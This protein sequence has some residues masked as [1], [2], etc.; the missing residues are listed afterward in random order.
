MAGYVRQDVANEIEDGNTILAA[1]IDAEYDALASSFSASSGHK[2]D[3]TVGEGAPITVVG[4]SQNLIVSANS[5]T[6]KTDD[7]IDLGSP[8]LEFKD[9]YIDGVANVDSLVADAATVGGVAVTTATNTQTLTG[10]TINLTDNTLVATSAQ[11]ATAVTDET[12]TGNLVFSDSPALTGVPTAPTAAPGTDTTQIATTAYV[13][14]E[15]DVVAVLT[16]KTI[17]LSDNTLVATSAEL[18]AA[19]SDETGSGSLVF[20]NSPSLTGTPTAPTATTGNNTTQ[21][22]TTAFVKTAIDGLSTL[23]DATFNNPTINGGTITGGSISSLDTDLP[24]ADGGTGASSAPAARTALGLAIG[25]DVQAY[26]AGLQSISGLTTVA[27]RMLYTTGSDT[28]AVT[29]ITSLGRAVVGASTAADARTNLGLGTIA[30]QAASAVTITGGSITGIT[31]LPVADGG[32]GASTSANARTNLGLAIG[33]DVQ[34]YDAGLQSISGLT[35]SA[36]KMIYT[37]ASDTYSAATLTSFARTLLDDANAAAMQ[38]TLGLGALA[39][40]NKVAVPSDINATGTPSGNTVLYG[41]GNWGPSPVAIANADPGVARIVDA[42]L[43]TT[44][45][46]AGQD[47]VAARMIARGHGGI[48]TL[49]FAARASGGTNAFGTTIAGSSLTPA[50]A[51][52]TTAGS[53]LT[54]TW[55]SLGWAASGGGEAGSTLWQRIA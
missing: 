22:A 17:D 13:I 25:T 50:N 46:S 47:W 24:I 37:T 27:D 38:A 48:G 10:K 5:I 55:R 15:R 12:G 16:N 9:L 26:D 29:P 35:T 31:D 4:P 53:T 3:G 2:H 8:S 54:G 28:Y 52:G 49:A 39:V 30:T 14:D 20:A 21:I 41:D 18:A 6:P 19:I 7:T 32:T 51:V 23:P 34:A 44:V 42:A 43:S 36:D 33:T 45:T 1:P 11:L 40:K